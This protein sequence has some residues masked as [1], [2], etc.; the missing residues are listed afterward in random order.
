MV[1]RTFSRYRLRQAVAE[2]VSTV[3][4]SQAS[5]GCFDSTGACAAIALRKAGVE[6]IN[7]IT[8][9]E[10]GEAQPN[11]VE[12]SPRP[13]ART[14]ALQDFSGRSDSPRGTEAFGFV[15]SN[16]IAS[17]S[18]FFLYDGLIPRRRMHL[19]MGPEGGF[20]SASLSTLRA[21][22]LRGI[23]RHNYHFVAIERP[24]GRL[25]LRSVAGPGLA[26]QV[27][28]RLLAIGTRN[29]CQRCSPHEC[30]ELHTLRTLQLVDCLCHGC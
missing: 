3:V 1:S 6:R 4:A 19:P 11:A 16:R 29:P 24:Q 22:E 18:T 8:S 17:H 25:Q 10:R 27:L 23:G 13:L 14:V 15:A 30:E 12:R 28:F 2:N 7:K 20:C 26:R 5:M 9:S 21:G